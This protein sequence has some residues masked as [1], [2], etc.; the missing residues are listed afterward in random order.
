MDFPFKYKSD[1]VLVLLDMNFQEYFG[2]LRY[3]NLTIFLHQLAS[4]HFGKVI[5]FTIGGIYTAKYIYIYSTTI[6]H[7]FFVNLVLKRYKFVNK[8]FQESWMSLN[9][10]LFLKPHACKHKST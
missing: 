5:W 4:C 3:S 2:N 10:Q 6:L 9:F 1:I 7:S 8:I